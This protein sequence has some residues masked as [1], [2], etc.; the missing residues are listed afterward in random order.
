MLFADDA[1]KPPCKGETMVLVKNRLTDH[2]TPLLFNRQIRNG[3]GGAYLSAEGT[4]IFAIAE[5]RDQLRCVDCRQS[6]LQNRGIQGIFQAD[7]H[8][9]TATDTGCHKG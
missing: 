2:F 1:I 7:L 5:S 8:A 6:T 9:F 3:A 4:I